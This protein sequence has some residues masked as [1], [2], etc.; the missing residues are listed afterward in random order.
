MPLLCQW[1]GK[2]RSQ[3]WCLSTKS[4][5]ISPLATCG[6]N[7]YVTLCRIQSNLTPC[8][9]L[10]AKTPSPLTHTFHPDHHYCTHANV[11]GRNHFVCLACSMFCA[12]PP[13]TLHRCTHTHFCY[14]APEFFLQSLF[15]F[16]FF[17]SAWQNQDLCRETLNPWPPSNVTT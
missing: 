12:A 9:S 2:W 14:W 1:S 13:L 3:M 8:D 11:S 10:Y 17:R 6:R 16:F 15:F 7:K 5:Q 4:S